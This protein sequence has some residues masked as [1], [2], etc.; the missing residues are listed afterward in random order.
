MIQFLLMLGISLIT[1][2]LNVFFRDIEYIVNFI[3]KVSYYVTPV[4]YAADLLK[5]SKFEILLKLNPMTIIID[6]YR[7]I[8]IKH[9]FP[10][11]INLGL[12]LILSL[13]I[14]FIGVFVFKKLEK[15]LL[16]NY[17]INIRLIFNK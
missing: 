6:S 16:K 2:S 10:N 15:N 12:V 8:L 11:F 14:L 9:S 13:I 1:S 5:G 3:L 7:D 17:K 4:F